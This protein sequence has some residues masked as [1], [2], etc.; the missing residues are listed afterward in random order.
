MEEIVRFGRRLCELSDI[1]QS[2]QA[3]V[4]YIHILIALSHVI[5]T[6]T[7]EVLS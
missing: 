5:E 2:A 6:L 3:V 7:T 1:R 4:A